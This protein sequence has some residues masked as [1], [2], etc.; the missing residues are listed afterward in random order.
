MPTMTSHKHG[1]FTWIELATTDAAAAKRFYSELLGWTFDDNPMGPDMVYT[2]CKLGDERVAALYTMGA[3]RAGVPSHWSGYIA[4]ESADATQKVAVENGA[5]VVQ[6]A[7]DVMTFGRMAVLTDPTGATLCLWQAN[8][9]HGVTVKGEIGSLC[10][11]E[12]LTSDPDAARSFYTKT[13]GWTAKDVS[14]GPAGTYTLW[15]LPGDTSEN[16]GGMM[17]LPESM[18]GA[19]SHWLNYFRV[20]DIDASTKKAAALG[21]KVLVANQEVPNMGTMSVV[22]DPT[23]ATFALWLN[24]H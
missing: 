10:W 3:E 24:A 21:G 11:S 5:K 6:P 1:T 8:Q 22:Q 17:K 16:Q 18:Q 9:H 4:V 13:I 14:M 12:L 23:G 7:F 20:A 15:N 19:P 2:T